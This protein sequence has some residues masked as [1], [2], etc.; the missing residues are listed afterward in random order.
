MSNMLRY[1]MKKVENMQEQIC[2]ASRDR[3]SKTQKEMLEIK[4]INRSEACFG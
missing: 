2:T 4:N 3:N 1:L